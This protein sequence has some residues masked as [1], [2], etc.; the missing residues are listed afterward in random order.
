MPPQ[1]LYPAG[2]DVIQAA[3]PSYARCPEVWK[4]RLLLFRAVLKDI[5]AS[6]ILQLKL[7]LFRSKI[8][9]LLFFYSYIKRNLSINSAI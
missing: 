8:Y 3:S 6:Y 7:D 1:W 5:V 9:G 2:A 4:I